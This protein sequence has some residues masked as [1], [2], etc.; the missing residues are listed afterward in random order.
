MNQ[1]SRISTMK[2]DP[3]RRTFSN[4]KSVAARLMES[5]KAIPTVGKKK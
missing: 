4:V 2:K 5:P 1:S 3:K